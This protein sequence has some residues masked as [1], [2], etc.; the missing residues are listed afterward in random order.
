MTQP[1]AV[2]RNH[3]CMTQ[4]AAVRRNRLFMTQP[5]AGRRNHLCMTQPDS[6]RR[7]RLCVTQPDSVR[8]N[9]FCMTQPDAAR[10]N[11]L[12]MT[13]PDAARRNRLCMTQPD[14]A[15]RNRLG[16]WE[17]IVRGGL[18]A[19]VLD[20]KRLPAAEVVSVV[21]LATRDKT[22]VRFGIVKEQTF[23]R[24]AGAAVLIRRS[25]CQKRCWIS[26]V[27]LRLCCATDMVRGAIPFFGVGTDFS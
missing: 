3:L 18:G 6:V 1:V 23:I 19:G 7:N 12:C 16:L 25:P 20:A 10:R 5:D 21:D 9:H 27:T 8:R 4:P 13:Q 22:A 26:A 11:R 15:R 14:A 24:P 17:G 2:R